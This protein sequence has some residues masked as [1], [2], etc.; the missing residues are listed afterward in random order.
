MKTNNTEFKAVV[1]GFEYTNID[2][3]GFPKAVLVSNGRSINE[4]EDKYYYP[5]RTT[6]YYPQDMINIKSWYDRA[7]TLSNDEM[8]LMIAYIIQ[9][10]YPMSSY[11]DNLYVVKTF[12]NSKYEDDSWNNISSVRGDD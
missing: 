10:M 9:L 11:T 8:S 7:L 5:A 2:C 3:D 1:E 4:Y 6:D 12:L